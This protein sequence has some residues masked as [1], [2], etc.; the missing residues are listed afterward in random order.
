LAHRIPTTG[1]L[2]REKEGLRKIL[3]EKINQYQIPVGEIAKI[4]SGEDFI[5][6][7]GNRILNSE[8]TLPPSKL[9]RAMPFAATLATTN[10]F[11]T[12]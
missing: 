11:S 1:F 8:L 2:F 6:G 3:P 9:R 10:Q 5:D 12:K 7:N 4:K